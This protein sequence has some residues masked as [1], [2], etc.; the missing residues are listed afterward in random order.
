MNDTNTAAS[1]AVADILAYHQRDEVG[2][3]LTDNEV[4]D[5]AATLRALSAERDAGQGLTATISATIS[6]TTWRA[7]LAALPEDVRLAFIGS[8]AIGQIARLTETQFAFREVS[9]RGPW[10]IGGLIEIFPLLLDRP[11]ATPYIP[12]PARGGIDVDELLADLG[13]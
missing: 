4:R 2:M 9:G 3:T 8:Y 7:D 12:P 13:L 11:L 5:V 6:A 1:G 10:H